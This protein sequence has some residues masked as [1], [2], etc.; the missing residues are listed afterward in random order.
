MVTFQLPFTVRQTRSNSCSAGKPSP[1]TCSGVPA[2]PCTGVTSSRPTNPP[3]G[4]ASTAS[5][6]S[7][8]ARGA[9]DSISVNNSK[10]ASSAQA[11]AIT[12]P[13]R[14][15]GS[16]GIA[17]QWNSVRLL[18]LDLADD[19]LELRGH[20]L[21]RLP[22]LRLPVEPGRRH[23]VGEGAA[24]IARRDDPD[25]GPEMIRRRSLGG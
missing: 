25:A 4:S 1:V 8:G 6:P 13:F 5:G 21:E 23:L 18:D 16:M 22:G 19:D 7:S 10:A 17:F 20:P 2:G 11:R 24:R 14:A 9:A 3:A 15:R 12:R